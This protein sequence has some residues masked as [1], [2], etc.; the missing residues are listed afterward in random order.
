[1]QRHIQ[2]EEGQVCAAVLLPG[3]PDRARLVAEEY[4]EGAAVYNRH[5]GL[6][7]AS[8]RYNGM[9][10]SVQATGMGG[11]SAAII[12]QELINLGARRFIRIGTCGALQP[13]IPAASLVIASAACACDGASARLSA[14]PGFAPAAHFG[15]T[16]S[17]ALSAREGGSRPCAVGT[18]ASLDLFY[19]PDPALHARLRALGVLAVEMET[20]AL[21]TLAA[22]R[23]IVKAHSQCVGQGQ[24]GHG[25]EAAAIFVVSDIIEGGVRA[26]EEEMRSALGEMIRSALRALERGQ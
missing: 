13:E 25:I 12:I 7:G 2:A 10:V 24:I 18:V 23:R 1:M 5:R 22:A 8:G 17:L 14:L 15:L 26:A 20:A 9:D 11:G 4:L 16:M 21:F 3:D 19:E 6:Y